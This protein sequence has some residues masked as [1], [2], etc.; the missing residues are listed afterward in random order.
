MLIGPDLTAAACPAFQGRTA[1]VQPS[2]LHINSTY[3]PYLLR[4]AQLQKLI[5]DCLSTTSTLVQ[6]RR[7]SATIISGWPVPAQCFRKDIPGIDEPRSQIA[8]SY[9]LGLVLLLVAQSQ[10]K[11]STVRPTSANHSTNDQAD[12]RIGTRCLP[13][14]PLFPRYPKSLSL[15]DSARGP[16]PPQQSMRHRGL[17]VRQNEW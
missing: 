9:R 3:H 14:L 13:F 7:R 15:E 17:R 5:V 11:S 6:A 8:S 4:T 10:N 16:H 12:I 2:D 1:Q